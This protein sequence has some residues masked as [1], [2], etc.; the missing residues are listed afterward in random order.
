MWKMTCRYQNKALCSSRCTSNGRRRWPPTVGP[1][2]PH[3]GTHPQ[4]VGILEF[5]AIVDGVSRPLGGVVHAELVVARVGHWFRSGTYG[6]LLTLPTETGDGWT[7]REATVEFSPLFQKMTCW[8]GMD[9]KNFV[10][11]LHVQP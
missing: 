3:P 4:T 9:M 10:R 7:G 2:Q 8:V 5:Y 1:P 11:R 6:V